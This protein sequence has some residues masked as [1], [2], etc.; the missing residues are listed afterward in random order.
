MKNPIQVSA[1]LKER[2]LNAIKNGASV[3]SV[4]KLYDVNRSTVYRWSITSKNNIVS[5]LK[6]PGSGRPSKIS[7][8]EIDFLLKLMTKPATFYG[9]ESPLWTSRTLEDFIKKKLCKKVHR[10][11]ICRMLTEEN[12]TY[13]KVEKRSYN[14]DERAQNHWI[15]VSIPT[16][17]KYVKR[18]RAILY[19]FDEANIQLNCKAGKSW[20]PKG[21]TPIIRQST[22]RGSINA[23]SAVNSQGRLVFS[24][25]EEPIKAQNVVKFFNQLMGQNPDRKVVVVL[26]GA[27]AHRSKLVKDFEKNNTNIKLYSLPSYS[28]EFNP[29]EKIWGH[30]K[31]TELISHGQATTGDLIKFARNKLKSMS[32]RPKLLRA[33]FRRCEVAKFFEI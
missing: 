16:I 27:S 14:A 1:D 15:K 3:G 31:S 23:M 8:D 30:L 4:A 2:A 28:P 22:N 6:N 29:D 7:Q 20:S 5:R 18:N 13:K 33:L 10:S 19:F 21:K 11:T 25:T 24:L 32:R 9:Y 17:K 12:L 26:D